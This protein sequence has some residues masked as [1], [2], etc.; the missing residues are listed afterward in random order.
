[1]APTVL[2]QSDDLLQDKIDNLKEDIKRSTLYRNRPTIR[3]TRDGE[4]IQQNQ[5]AS[6]YRRPPPS[7][8]FLRE[9]SQQLQNRRQAYLANPELESIRPVMVDE[10]GLKAIHAPHRKLVDIPSRSDHAHQSSVRKRFNGSNQRK[11]R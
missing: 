10:E 7:E 8:A 1:M 2:F 11:L 4:A 3:T 5:A 6:S 9:K